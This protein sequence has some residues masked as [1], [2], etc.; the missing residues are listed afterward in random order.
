M[1]L[2]HVSCIIM[3]DLHTILGKCPLS[4][5]SFL[6]KL[7]NKE[8]ILEGKLEKVV[9]NVARNILNDVLLLASWRSAWKLLSNDILYVWKKK[10]L[11]SLIIKRKT[12]W[13]GQIW[14]KGNKWFTDTFLTKDSQYKH[15]AKRTHTLVRNYFFIKAE[16]P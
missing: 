11:K 8:L 5:Q 3:Y 13:S 1:K 2:M 10:S 14:Q 9:R 7:F 16:A 12:S 4:C 15:K 6:W